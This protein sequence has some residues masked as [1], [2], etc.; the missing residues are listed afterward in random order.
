MIAAVRRAMLRL[1]CLNPEE[2]GP[3]AEGNQGLREPVV[4]R[5]EMEGYGTASDADT[6]LQTAGFGGCYGIVLL[7][8]DNKRTLA[9]IYSGHYPPPRLPQDVWE[10]LDAFKDLAGAADTAHLYHLPSYWDRGYEQTERFLEYFGL[11]H[12]NIVIHN[13]AP[14]AV[15]VDPRGVVTP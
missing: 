3:A 13:T 4:Q 7:G 12:L 2:D 15:E 1:L 14:W 11:A 9:H 8:P 6:T 5:V 10:R